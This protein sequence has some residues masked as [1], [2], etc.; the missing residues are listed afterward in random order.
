M[1][2]SDAVTFVGL[3]NVGEGSTAVIKYQLQDDAGVNVAKANITAATMT[4][5]LVSDGTEITASTDVLPD[6]T[7]G[8]AMRRVITS[9]ENTIKSTATPKPKIEEHVA[10][11]V[12]TFSVGSEAH[13]KV[14]NYLIRVQDNPRH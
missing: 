10:K 12:T 13:Q 1:G 5:Y 4:I 3:K 2:A 9:A 14:R 8:G 11:F 7:T 6:Y